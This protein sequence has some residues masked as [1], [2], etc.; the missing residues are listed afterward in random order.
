MSVL[1]KRKIPQEA[2]CNKKRRIQY[3]QLKY[4]SLIFNVGFHAAQSYL[5]EAYLRS[6]WTNYYYKMLKHII[7]KYYIQVTLS[8]LF[9]LSCPYNLC[10]ELQFEYNLVDSRLEFCL[11]NQNYNIK[12]DS[13]KII[14]FKGQ[15]LRLYNY[16]VIND[17]FCFQEMQI[18]E[19]IIDCGL[20]SFKSTIICNAN[21]KSM[22]KKMS[23]YTLGLKIGQKWSFK[24]RINSIT[25]GYNHQIL[26]DE[27]GIAYGVGDNDSGQLGLGDIDSVKIFTK[28]MNQVKKVHCLH[29][30]SFIIRQDDTIYSTGSTIWTKI[31]HYDYTG[32]IKHFTIIPYFA[33]RQTKIIDIQH[34]YTY[35]LFFDTNKLM[36]LWGWGRT[37]QHFDHM[38]PGIMDDKILKYCAGGKDVFFF[39][40][41]DNDSIGFKVWGN[42]FINKTN[43]S[44]VNIHK[45]YQFIGSEAPIIDLLFSGRSLFFIQS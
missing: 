19:N 44:T 4:Q 26:V 32:S 41:L 23:Y 42:N 27:Y 38:V 16:N 34:G 39:V 40:K 13:T 18:E 2:T 20:G 29:M 21:S 30:S 10:F 14:L 9:I 45:L 33:K 31:G 25:G 3:E 28:I 6:N 7:Q 35:T 5:V 1:L 36:Y 12:H 24:T 22:T 17:K 15:N 8:S 43:N 37:F 11:N